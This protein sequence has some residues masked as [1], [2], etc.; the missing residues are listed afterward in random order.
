MTTRYLR[1]RTLLAMALLCAS[2]APMNAGRQKAVTI[3]SITIHGPS[4]V[5]NLQGNSADRRIF[6]VLPPSYADVP[7]RRYPVVYLLHG[8]MMTANDLMGLAKVEN[9]ATAA[10]AGGATEMILVVPDTITLFGGSAYSSSPT[11]GDFENFIARDLVAFVD[12]R[13]RTIADRRSRGLAGHSMGGYGVLRI[14]MKHPDVFSSL[15]ALSPCCLAPR[16]ISS[17]YGRKLEA[18]ALPQI[19]AS[20]LGTRSTFAGAAA[21]SPAPDKP[22]LFLDIGTKNGIVQNDVV[23]R[24][25]ANA[26][27]AMLPQYLPALRHMT[28]IAIDIG[29]RD[30]LL[31][32]DSWMHRELERYGIAH[33][34]EVYPGDHMNHIADRFTNRVM[35]F[36]GRHLRAR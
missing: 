34:W 28:G 29:D 11:V 25:A 24:W 32:S 16:N 10:F 33:D 13:Y 18:M 15:Y 8:F 27:I 35:P 20:D 31:A 23:A 5:G 4:L 6:I 30:E 22:P 9:G 3:Q 1:W 36:F 12:A 14:G 19:E 2:A 21:W 7:T 17:D 26:P